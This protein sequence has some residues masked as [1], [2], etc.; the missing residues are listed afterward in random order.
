MAAQD[1]WEAIKL[2]LG[3]NG[4]V[5]VADLSCKLGVTEETI[6]RDLE[7]LESEGLLKRTYGGAIPV[8]SRR[9]ADTSFHKRS[10][11]H[12]REKRD[13][14]QKVLPLLEGKSTIAADSS[15]TAMEAV[16]LLRDQGDLTLLTNSTVVFQELVDAKITVV[17]PGGEFD[18]N[19]LSL[20]GEGTKK[21]LRQY[22]VDALLFSC[23]GL[24]KTGVF[25]SRES[26]VEIKRILLEQSSELILLA[27]HSKFSRTAFV[28]HVGLDCI[29]CIV[30]D[31]DPSDEWKELCEQNGIKLVF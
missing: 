15:T 22:H 8:E 12:V 3:E 5:F 16:R 26:E 17:S 10:E 29:D 9:H 19:S 27:D 18:K 28:R 1:R 4:Q 13:I 30:T 6:R 21:A 2:E 20:R 14:A 25:D 11:Q 7:R 24:D 31:R 23:K